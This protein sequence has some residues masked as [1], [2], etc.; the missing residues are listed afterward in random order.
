VSATEPREPVVDATQMQGAGR[1]AYWAL[2]GSQLR[3]NRSAMA[4]WAALKGLWVAAVAAPLLA[5]NVPLFRIADGRP[6]FPLLDHLFDRTVFP[7]GVDVFF[8]LI[9]VAVPF[10]LA[11]RALGRMRAASAPRGA[12]RVMA[13]VALSFIAVLA[14]TAV[15]SRTSLRIATFGVGP[16]VGIAAYAGAG[17]TAATPRWRGARA[18]RW[19]VVAVF[20]AGFAAIM[21]DGETRRWTEWTGARAEP[22]TFALFPPVPFHPDNVG[23]PAGLAADRGLHSTPS[24]SN[25]L[26]CDAGGRDVVARL[27]FGARISLTIGLVGVSIY[28]LIGVILG[29]LAGYYLG[30]VDLVI[31]R[32]VEIVI[33][34]PVLFLL[35]TIIAVFDTRSI[36]LIMA[37]IGFVGWPGVARLVRGEFLRQRNLDYVTAAKSQG[38]PERKIIF[39]HV[40]PNCIGPVLVS[41]T[42]GVASAILTESGIAFLGLGDPNAASWGEML[43]KGRESLHW[44]LI[45]APGFAIFFVVTVFNLLGEGLRDALDP[46]LRR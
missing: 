46:K 15:W 26:G 32:L 20:V 23:E 28:I 35:L 6:G 41:A 17:G 7:N 45:L 24:A 16:L 5:F 11:G 8:N 27:L 33:C 21:R 31:S 9:L 37:A 4:A 3:K 13:V 19:L 2:V 12:S 29:S 34:F 18:M 40:L 30:K 14:W 1:V 38:I 36:F 10:A 43:T 44:H 22:S 39:G 42:F 25:W